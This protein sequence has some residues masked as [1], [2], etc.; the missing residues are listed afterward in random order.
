MSQASWLSLIRNKYLLV[1]YR[2]NSVR[3]LGLSPHTQTRDLGRWRKNKNTNIEIVAGKPLIHLD[4]EIAKK[5]STVLKS[6][7]IK[8]NLPTTEMKEIETEEIAEIIE[9]GM[10]SMMAGAIVETEADQGKNTERMTNKEALNNNPSP[11]P[12]KFQCQFKS[13]CRQF[14]DKR[15]NVA[16]DNVLVLL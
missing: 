11:N 12:R 5:I 6:T 1:L 8:K 9:T 10:A 2:K 16:N 14:L 3:D 4:Q 7:E 13:P 15:E